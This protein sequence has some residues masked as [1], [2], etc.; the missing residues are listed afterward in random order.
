[1]VLERTQI[2]QNPEGKKMILDVCCGSEMIYQGWNQKL[3]DDYIGIDVRKGDF[4]FKL[5]SNF[6]IQRIVVKPKVLADMG[7]LPFKDNSFRSI[8]CDTPHMDLGTLTGFWAKKYG[9][10]TK[11]EM[12]K[13]LRLLNIEANR[14]LT[15]DGSFILKIMPALWSTY[16][17]VLT[18]FLF[19]L[20]IQTVRARGAIKENKDTKLSAFW[21][22]GYKVASN[23]VQ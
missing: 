16:E 11:E 14:V 9:S 1:L 18:N 6:S 5:E 23:G 17:E 15:S 21:A 2:Y 7:Y 13:T 3:K 22:I 10:W 19:Y 12:A 8:V 4:S 20:P